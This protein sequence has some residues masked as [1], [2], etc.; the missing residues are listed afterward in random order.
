[1]T[2]AI[3]GSCISMLCS[4]SSVDAVISSNN[5]VAYNS[6]Y[7]GNTATTAADYG[8][9]RLTYGNYRLKYGNYYLPI[10][11]QIHSF[12]LFFN[13]PIFPP[14]TQSCCIVQN[15]CQSTVEMTRDEPCETTSHG[16]TLAQ[17]L[18]SSQPLAHSCF[19]YIWWNDLCFGAARNIK[20]KITHH[21]LCHVLITLSS[22]YTSR[23]KTFQGFPGDWPPYLWP[24]KNL[25]FTATASHVHCATE[26]DSRIASLG[27]ILHT[28][29]RQH[30]TSHVTIIHTDSQRRRSLPWLSM[31][32]S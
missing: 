29:P 30:N 15:V 3:Y 9:Y 13:Q 20:V 14:C 25:S 21:L 22:A 5:P 2:L 31:V 23:F 6:L 32:R 4:S 17:T 16:T 10:F 7:T 19:W 26:A 1:M 27:K 8:N 24:N 18:P 28:C 12:E 11:Q